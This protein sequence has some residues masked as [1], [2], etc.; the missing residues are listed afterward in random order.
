MIPSSHYL[1]NKVAAFFN[2]PLSILIII[3]INLLWGIS[4]IFPYIPQTDT[5]LFLLWIFIPD[6]PLYT[7][8]FAWFVYKRE[9]IQDNYQ[10][11]VWILCFSLIKIGLAAPAI[12]Y[13][14]PSEYH[15]LPILGFELPNIYPFD[16]F[17]LILLGQGLVISAFFLSRSIRYFL[18]ATIWLIINDIS[19][20]FFKTL[21][22]YT[23]MSTQIDS[24]F[25]FYTLADLS[26]ILI[27]LFIYLKRSSTTMK[28]N[29]P[30]VIV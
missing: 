26:I 9:S 14:F 5:V 25:L 22:D 20:F 4:G 12:F 30:S 10:P 23:A 13:L 24:L 18:I 8:L 2:N 11:F 17:H 19:D 15:T 29:A 27:G 3:F 6:C 21:P 16:Y 28:E 7:L 1:K